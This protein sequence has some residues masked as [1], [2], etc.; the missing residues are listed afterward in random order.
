[1]PPSIERLMV[2]PSV[3]AGIVPS[4]ARMALLVRKMRAA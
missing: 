3:R 1:M 2:S 4:T